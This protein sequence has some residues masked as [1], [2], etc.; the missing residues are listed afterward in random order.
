MPSLIKGSDSFNL[1]TV[2]KINQS[3]H[4]VLLWSGQQH[5]AFI[6][7][8]RLHGGSGFKLTQ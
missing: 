1:I 5:L 6:Y 7:I 8:E 2:T 3:D 4:A